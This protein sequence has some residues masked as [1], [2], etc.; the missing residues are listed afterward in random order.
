MIPEITLQD[1][2]WDSFFENLFEP[3]LKQGLTPGRVAVQH[4]GAYVVLTEAG[5]FA[6]ELPGRLR[7]EASATADLPAPG[8]WVAVR[9]VGN[10]PKV[11]IHSV[12]PRRS[13]FSRKAA[14]TETEEQVL[15]ANVDILFL[16]TALD[17]NF[18]PRRIERYLTLA[19]ESGALPVIVL[20][21]ADLCGD[22]EA[23]REAVEAVAVGVDIHHTSSVTGEGLD[24]LLQYLQRGRTVA[25][26]GSSGVGKSTL[27]NHLVGEERMATQEI[28]SDGKGRHTTSHRELVLLPTGGLILDTPGMRELQL[29]DA[30]EGIDHAFLDIAVL[31]ADCR[32][33]DCRHQ[34]EPGCG[35]L[36]A[37]SDGSLPTERLDSYRKLQ[38]ELRALELKQNKRAAADERRKYRSQARSRRKAVWTR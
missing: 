25:A 29:W 1:L 18:N 21:K 38:R 5:E 26:L 36:A 28:R 27:I 32:F 19:W 14:G 17:G 15:A 12:L 33:R 6:A 31:A 4:R 20:S 3:Y 24:G 23:A 13:K 8:D 16:I 37:V 22:L 34:D 9:Q 2:G 7:H 11:L 35:V 10:E 30:D